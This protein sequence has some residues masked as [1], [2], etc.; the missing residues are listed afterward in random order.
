MYIVTMATDIASKF[1]T[2]IVVWYCFCFSRSVV[3]VW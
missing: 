2:V 1:G 3:A